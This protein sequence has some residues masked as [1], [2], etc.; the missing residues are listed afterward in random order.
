VKAVH[1]EPSF[2]NVENQCIT[3][4]FTLRRQYLRERF[5][6]QIMDMYREL[7]ADIA[8]D[9]C[10]SRLTLPTYTDTKRTPYLPTYQK[11]ASVSGQNDYDGGQESPTCT[12]AKRTTEDND[13]SSAEKPDA[14]LG[15]VR[16][17]RSARSHSRRPSFNLSH[18]SSSVKGTA[19]MPSSQSSPSLLDLEL[20]YLGDRKDGF[21]S[22]C[23]GMI[24]LT[25]PED[26]SSSETPSKE[27]P[28]FDDGA[29]SSGELVRSLC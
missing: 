21:C 26:P 5:S 10:F 1:L 20:S 13:S 6:E 18:S 25:P 29:S 24:P 27:R 15:A 16:S 9:E 19:W 14:K 17:Q 12:C 2:F 7:S 8:D 28:P 4:T 11:A 23:G 22:K 3:P